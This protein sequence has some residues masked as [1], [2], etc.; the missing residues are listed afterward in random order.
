M[1]NSKKLSFEEAVRKR[2]G[3]YIGAAPNGKGIV[4]LVKHLILNL[5]YQSNAKLFCHFS[6]WGGNRFQLEIRSDGDIS[7]FLSSLDHKRQSLQNISRHDGYL[8]YLTILSRTLDIENISSSK[9]ILT[10]EMDN[11]IFIDT[12]IDFNYLSDSLMRIAA[13]NRDI[14]ILLTNHTQAYLNQVY[15]DYPQG[16]KYLFDR[17]IT[18]QAPMCEFKLCYDESI[19]T[20]HYQVY[21]AY[22][23]DW[24]PSPKIE[25]FIDNHPSCSSNDFVKGVLKGFI[26]GVRKVA[27]NS[28]HQEYKIEKNKFYNGLILI[29]S[30]HR[31][32][33]QWSETSKGYYEGEDVKEEIKKVFEDLTLR[34]FDTNNDVAEKFL[35]RFYNGEDIIKK[36]IGDMY[37]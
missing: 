36:T 27:K 8:L 20:N 19:G 32:D 6:I 34:F 28:G 10:W 12:A 17:Y 5:Y 3:M 11:E 26:S 24:H 15:H 13:L 30:V 14:K 35:H 23:M 25:S 1:M 37:R 18:E 31:D 29:C 16:L 7:D 21:L 9:I 33:Y 2:P 4:Y 22:R